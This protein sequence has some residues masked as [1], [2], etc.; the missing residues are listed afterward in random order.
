MH[1]SAPSMFKFVLFEAVTH[2]M[3]FFCNIHPFLTPKLLINITKFA[4]WKVYLIA[5]PQKLTLKEIQNT[6]VLLL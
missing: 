3:I 6:I 5:C 1:N 4:I 2:W